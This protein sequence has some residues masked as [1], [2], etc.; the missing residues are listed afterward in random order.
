M[1]N[2]LSRESLYRM[3]SKRGNSEIKRLL[4]LLRA[5]GFRLSIEAEGRLT[6]AA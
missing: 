2:G 5:M 4:S 3:L 1:R 6:T